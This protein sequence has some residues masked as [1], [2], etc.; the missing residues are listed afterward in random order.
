M[1]WSGSS[2]DNN[3]QNNGSFQKTSNGIPLLRRKLDVK[4][5]TPFGF[6]NTLT[7]IRNIFSPLPLRTAEISSVGGVWI[8]SGMTQ[9]EIV[10]SCPGI[11]L[12]IQSLLIIFSGCLLF[13]VK[14]T[15]F[16]EQFALRANVEFK[17]WFNPSSASD[18]P[19]TSKMVWH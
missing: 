12:S 17:I 18:L 11:Y 16:D 8:F 4:T 2:G 14:W 15:L 5:P 1:W 13:L 7:L 6:P 19:L 9:Y 10:W 3:L